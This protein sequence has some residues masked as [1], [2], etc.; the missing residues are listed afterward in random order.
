MTFC[1]WGF[2]ALCSVTFCPR[3]FVAL[4]VTFCPLWLYVLFVV[5]GFMFCDFLSLGICGS[6]TFCPWGFVA[7]CSVT[8]VL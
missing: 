1:P 6:V 8:F 7:L 4:C 3:G 5:C 2:V